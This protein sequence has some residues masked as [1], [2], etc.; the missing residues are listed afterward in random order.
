MHR[1]KAAST[2]TLAIMVNVR[3]VGQD[4]KLEM[5]KEAL[6]ELPLIRRDDSFGI[7]EDTQILQMKTSKY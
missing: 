3:S 6:E 4:G 1:V 7:T 2:S 5:W